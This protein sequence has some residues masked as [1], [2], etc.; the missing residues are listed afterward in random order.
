[1]H[2]RYHAPGTGN[3]GP[4][5]AVVEAEKPGDRLSHRSATTVMRE[6]G[7]YMELIIKQT[8]NLAEYTVPLSF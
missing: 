2:L 6:N 1:M 8:F 4:Y 5:T 3:L 7:L